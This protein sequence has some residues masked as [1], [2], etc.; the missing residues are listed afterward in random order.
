MHNHHHI[1]FIFPYSTD[2]FKK[3]YRLI[4]DAQKTTHS[5]AVYFDH[6]D[7]Q[8]E[9]L[10][11]SYWNICHPSVSSDAYPPISPGDIRQPLTCLLPEYIHLYVLQSYRND[12]KLQTHNYCIYIFLSP[13][14][15]T[16]HALKA[17][18]V[19]A[20]QQFIPFHY[21]VMIIS[22]YE[23]ATIY[24]CIY[25]LTDFHV[26]STLR[27]FTKTAVKNICG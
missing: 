3:Q 25:M 8:T 20:Y 10:Q 19:C 18:H 5:S 21:W 16:Q 1:L 9:Y 27:P 17:L 11:N 2:I 13:A 6:A 22:S 14:S 7:T 26:I 12:V 4:T 24:A 15:F 23:Y